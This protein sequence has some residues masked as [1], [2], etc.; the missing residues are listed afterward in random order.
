MSGW[1][2]FDDGGNPPDVLTRR[3]SE[4]TAEQSKKSSQSWVKFE[5]EGAGA[6]E[7]GPVTSTPTSR[8]HAEL[9][10]SVVPQNTGEFPTPRPTYPLARGRAAHAMATAR[11]HI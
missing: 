4:G 8:G 11:P 6:G 10:G 2:S 5:V 9:H 7:G 3:D 1:V